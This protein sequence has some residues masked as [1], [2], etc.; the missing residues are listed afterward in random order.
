MIRIIFT[1]F[2]L[3]LCA[4]I[5]MAQSKE[6][7]SSDYEK[8]MQAYQTQ[9]YEIGISYFTSDIA[10]HPLHYESY[11]YRGCCYAF[12]H[13]ASLAV[14]D[15]KI[16]KKHLTDN[17]V[18][19]YGLGFAYNDLLDFD[20]AIKYLD[21]TISIDSKNAL[22]YNARGISY[23]KLKKPRIAIECYS[24]AIKLDSDFA[25]AYNNRGT[26]IY[27]N[28]DIEPASEYDIKSAIK[29]FDKAII[30]S[31]NFCLA[32]RNR[33]LSFMFIGKNE[34]ALKD[35]NQALKCDDRNPVYYLDRGSLYTTTGQYSLAKEDFNSALSLNP[36]IAEAYILIGEVRNKEGSLEDAI[37]NEK[38]AYTIDA[39]FTGLS[40]YN[41]ARFYCMAKE[42]VQMLKY[43]KMARKERYF[44]PINNLV[45]FLKDTDFIKFKN[46]K[47]FDDFRNSVRNNRL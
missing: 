2:E 3:V 41:I 33:G 9:S 38:Q 23:Q 24:R 36:K 12:R 16:A 7:D 43:L 10:K 8:G 17:A 4:H 40:Y 6:I 5:G 11:M 42:K 15:L 39:T 27:E 20:N 13:N 18:I 21:K 46:D 31:P 32:L 14:Y 44:K 30:F 26:A 29:D 45:N 25:I 37:L 28:Q 22:A 34:L 47:D 19:D 35:F 1:V